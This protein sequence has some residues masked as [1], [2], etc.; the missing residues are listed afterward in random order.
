MSARGRFA[1]A[2]FISQVPLSCSPLTRNDAW[3]L[4]VIY[5]GLEVCR[6]PL[7][8]S[9]HQ[10]CLSQPYACIP[11]TSTSP[12]PPLAKLGSSCP[13]FN[14]GPH[15]QAKSGS[16]HLQPLSSHLIFGRCLLSSYVKVFP[17]LEI[18]GGSAQPSTALFSQIQGAFA[19]LRT[20]PSAV[21]AAW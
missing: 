12:E 5:L 15:S 19:L 13:C 10:H 2:C 9:E 3:R 21:F 11:L 16:A 17:K 1:K 4:A 14:L 8:F 7:C 6:S 18:T 20:F